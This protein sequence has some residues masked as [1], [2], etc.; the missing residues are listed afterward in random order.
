MGKIE[1]EI[2][3]VEPLHTSLLCGKSSGFFTFALRLSHIFVV[4]RVESRFLVP[5]DL[6]AAF[7]LLPASAQLYDIAVHFHGDGPSRISIDLNRY[8]TNMCGSARG[9]ISYT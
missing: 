3:Q 1:Q 5:A 7:V 4:G 6:L 9:T 8:E 2:E